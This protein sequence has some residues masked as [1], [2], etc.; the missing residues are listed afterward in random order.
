MAT[1]I[2][3]DKLYKELNRIMALIF[4]ESEKLKKEIKN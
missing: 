3:D 2:P 1:E 4:P